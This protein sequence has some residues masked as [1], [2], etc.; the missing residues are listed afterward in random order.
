M[1]DQTINENLNWPNQTLNGQLLINALLTLGAGLY[2]VLFWRAELG[3]NALLFGSFLSGVVWL[4]HP[5]YRK[6]PRLWWLTLGVVLS[7]LAVVWQHSLL[8]QV[9]HIASIILLLGFAQ[10]PLAGKQG[11][12]IQVAEDLT[13]VDVRLREDA[14][15]PEGGRERQLLRHGGG[16]AGVERCRRRG[17]GAHRLKRSGLPAKP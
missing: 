9:T 10:L 13:Q 1:K 3:L 5:E 12:A 16:A 6:A 14:T 2:T 8:A 11:I 15:T 4:L 7:A 17:F